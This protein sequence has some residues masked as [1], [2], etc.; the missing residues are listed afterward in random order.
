MILDTSAVTAI[1]CGEPDTDRYI[2]AIEEADRLAIGAPTLVECGIV[3]QAK[4][5]EHGPADLD[6]FLRRLHVEVVPFGEYEASVA[7]YAFHA[8][9]KG[10]HSA[11]LNFGDC[12]SY[13]MAGTYNDV[14]LYKG[15]DF[16]RT[17]VRSA[18]NRSDE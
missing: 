16:S 7:R 3:A 12:L 10:R 15:D 1:L 11:G 5:G 8:F 17:P 13:A 14:L 18:L 9:G 4:L 6:N 2:A